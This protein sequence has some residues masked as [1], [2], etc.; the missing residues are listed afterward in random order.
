MGGLIEHI[1]KRVK[2]TSGEADLVLS[3]VSTK[4]V[5]KRE[6]LLEKGA[7][8]SAIY[9]VESGALRSF[10]V[11]E[12]G[13][14]STIMFA[15]EDWWITDMHCFIHGLP[16]MISIQAIEE[17]QVLVL[18]IKELDRLFQEKP[19]F[20]VFF[21]KLMENAYC[22]EQL[23]MIESLSLPAKVRY[24]NFLKKYPQ[25]AK[26]VPLKQIA[27]YLGITPEFL[28]AIRSKTA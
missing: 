25:I 18:S 24:E 5:K 21:R 15:V 1:E 7:L 13:K 17:S 2:L 16:A 4:R 27:S 3:L 26:K 11:S 8:C 22:R 28:S 9:F 6:I 23:R 20:N 19:V 12:S 14:A 10:F